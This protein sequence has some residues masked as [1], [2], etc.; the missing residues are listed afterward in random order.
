MTFEKTSLFFNPLFFICIPFLF[1]HFF[2]FLCSEGALTTQ[3]IIILFALY[4]K[5]KELYIVCWSMCPS[6]MDLM[7]MTFL[8]LFIYIEK[9]IGLKKSLLFDIVF[10]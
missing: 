2:L 7:Y 4:T 9:D 5:T 3:D 6:H 10:F 8:Q 1:L